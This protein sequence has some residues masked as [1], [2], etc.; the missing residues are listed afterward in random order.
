MEI[1]VIS[2]I[3]LFTRKSI[4][5]KNVNK[6]LHLNITVLEEVYGLLLMVRQ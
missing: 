4:Q 1:H 3:C 2:A 6:I 5:K